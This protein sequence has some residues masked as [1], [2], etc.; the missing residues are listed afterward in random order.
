V[1]APPKE[2]TLPPTSPSRN[3]RPVLARR[4]RE[5]TVPEVRLIGPDGDQVG[6]VTLVE[7]L[8]VAE[9]ANMDLVEV[10]PDAK[11]PVCKVLNWSKLQFTQEKERRN[12]LH[13]QRVTSVT[14]EIQ[15]R[16][17]IDTHDLHTKVISA[18]RFLEKGLRVRVTVNLHGRY[19]TRPES[20][21]DRL[22]DVAQILEEVTGLPADSF[23]DGAVQRA[24]R[25]IT[26]NLRPASVAKSK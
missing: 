13:R 26:Q 15:I 16:P 12:T 19:I 6:V 3:R 20:A 5:I 14:K 7:A 4:N 21:D 22:A 23:Y 17:E 25:K 2:V 10:A 11:P 18:V 8:R 1:S 24:G 9:A